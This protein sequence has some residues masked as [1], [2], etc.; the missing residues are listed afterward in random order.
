MSLQAMNWV[1][2]NSPATLGKRLVLLA[3]ADHAD[4]EGFDAYPSVATIAQ[5]ARM[6]E[7]AVQYALRQLE[8]DAAIFCLGTSKHGTRNY[9]INMQPVRP[10]SAT[11]NSTS[12]L[13]TTTAPLLQA[14]TLTM[15][16]S[17]AHVCTPPQI[18]HP[19]SELRHG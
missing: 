5:K 11:L 4:D 3:L 12:A 2:Q 19:Q 10:S 18:L 15:D 14:S 8:D 7:R 16:G 9:A 17:G 13:R 1:F 6:S